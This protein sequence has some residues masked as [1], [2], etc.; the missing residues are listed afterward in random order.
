[1]HTVNV[2]TVVFVEK[3]DDDVT[4]VKCEYSRNQPFKEIKFNVDDND[5]LPKEIQEFI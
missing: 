5:W 4:V 2:E 1:M 3:D